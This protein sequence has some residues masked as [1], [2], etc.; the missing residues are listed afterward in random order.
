MEDNTDELLRIIW[1]NDISN[2]DKHLPTDR[3]SLKTL[4][5]MEKP[6]ITLK[7]GEKSIILKEDLQK[8]ST[9]VPRML[10]EEI[11][12]P[13]VFRRNDDV[14][15]LDSDK[16]LEHW[17]VDTVLGFTTCSPFLLESYHRRGYYYP[18]ELGRFRKEF[19]SL[20]VV[21]IVSVGMGDALNEW[22]DKFGSDESSSHD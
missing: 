4:L 17:L 14:Y 13:L 21:A 2:I 15:E 7:S 20:V 8:L 3:K 16:E 11:L 9:V 10:W 19:P 5:D 22:E 6:E 18:H 12:L 1:K